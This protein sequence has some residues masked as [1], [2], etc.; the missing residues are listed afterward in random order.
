M[1][2]SSIDRSRSK[3]NAS[4]FVKSELRSGS[5]KPMQESP[6]RS[7]ILSDISTFA[8]CDS[9]KHLDALSKENGH[10]SVRLIELEEHN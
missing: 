9:K 3:L 7:K 10:L 6:E 1:N 2:Q 4:H 8:C 5:N